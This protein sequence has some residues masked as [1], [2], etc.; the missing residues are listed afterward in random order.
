MKPKT[1]PPSVVALT[2]RVIRHGALNNI[3]SYVD[4][5]NYI[6]VKHQFPMGAYDLRKINGDISLRYGVVGESFSPLGQDESVSVEERHVVYSDAEKVLCWL[7]NYKDSK[8]SYVD[9]NTEYALLFIDSVGKPVTS[10]V[11]SALDEFN[12]Q[13]TVIGNEV[14]MSGI[15]TADTPEYDLNLEALVPL[16]EDRAAFVARAKKTLA[17]VSTHVT[18]VRSSI[19]PWS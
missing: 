12:K 7:W 19:P 8:F 1:F 6:S 5:Y 18:P 14:L 9:E 11:Q 2:R 13:M 10:T 3:S 15:L 16:N 4:L 17:E